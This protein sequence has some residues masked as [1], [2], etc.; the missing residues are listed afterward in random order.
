[1]LRR[2][3][4]CYRE[5]PPTH[6]I[7]RKGGNTTEGGNGEF[8]KLPW[9]N[10]LSSTAEPLGGV[11]PLSVSF[12]SSTS[13]S[14][15]PKETTTVNDDRLNRSLDEADA[16]ITAAALV[17]QQQDNEFESVSVPSSSSSG[18]GDD[19]I[20]RA[21]A[22]ISSS[23]KMFDEGLLRG[24]EAKGVPITTIQELGGKSTRTHS[25]STKS[26]P[27]TIPEKS[28]ASRRTSVGNIVVES[29]T[30]PTIHTALS[31]PLSSSSSSSVST[32]Q[33][34]GT[35]VPMVMVNGQRIPGPRLGGLTSTN[36]LG[37]SNSTVVAQSVKASETDDDIV[38]LLRQGGYEGSNA[39]PLSHPMIMHPS[40]S[41]SESSY[42][43]LFPSE[44]TPSSETIFP[45]LITTHST[46]SVT[47]ASL[48]STLTSPI[49]RKPFTFSP[50]SPSGTPMDDK[51]FFTLSPGG[52]SVTNSFSP[53]K[54]SP[55]TALS[56]TIGFASRIP[57]LMSPIS[58][59]SSPS[60]YAP[61]T[62]KTPDTVPSVTEGY[63]DPV[64]L[65][66]LSKLSIPMESRTSPNIRELFPSLHHTEPSLIGTVDSI[67]NA[68][69]LNESN[70]SDISMIKSINTSANIVENTVPS[71]TSGTVS[72]FSD[73]SKGNLPKLNVAAEM[74][75]FLQ[76]N[77]DAKHTTVQPSLS[78]S[79][80]PSSVYISPERIVLEDPEVTVARLRRRLNAIDDAVAPK[81]AHYLPQYA[82]NLRTPSSI[83]AGTGVDRRTSLVTMV[84]DTGST[85]T[86]DYP[87]ESQPVVVVS[88]S[89]EE[90]DEKSSVPVNPLVKNILVNN[91]S[92]TLTLP[93]T[94]TLSIPVTVND[95][96]HFPMV[97]LYNPELRAYVPAHNYN[98]PSNLT[99]PTP[100]NETFT[101]PSTDW[102]GKHGSF[103]SNT[104]PFDPSPV[105]NHVSSSSSSAAASVTIHDRRPS[106]ISE[107][108]TTNKSKKHKKSK[109]GT[110]STS[111][112]KQEIVSMGFAS[113]ETLLER[114]RGVRE[115]KQ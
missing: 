41:S 98:L 34:I 62:T 105:T 82:A 33:V 76:K 110:S 26:S 83:P 89:E 108:S 30:H 93:D 4:T 17:V 106:H 24:L 97:L 40:S 70:V 113:T 54:S 38:A 74:D 59:S 60:S 28:N 47:T 61:T 58:S 44:N 84:A 107:T 63:N 75:E 10:T 112:H 77:Y 99:H 12:S 115:S 36:T 25:S 19:V 56:S 45:D 23:R 94:P 72:T 104:V 13:S 11:L 81:L 71:I 88:S 92:S 102:N 7:E 50:S 66:A 78:T 101:K 67:V 39:R 22:V 31:Y 68:V 43:P 64:L 9:M 111:K 85:V 103:V 15:I 18:G 3:Y 5:A 51:Q 69:N 2:I 114:L 35:S 42:I 48:S 65:D 100:N 37:T 95:T 86:M 29:S 87:H 14:F 6:P 46:N 21:M 27:D 73:P 91:D 96:P 49:I 57:R 79:S 90:N 8:S 52:E 80:E 55:L 32:L 1:M 16:A 109:T 20:S 53:L